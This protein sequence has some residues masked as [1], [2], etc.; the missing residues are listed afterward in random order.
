MLKSYQ[1]VKSFMFGYM[2]VKTS[3]T[4]NLSEKIMCWLYLN[5]KINIM[6]VDINI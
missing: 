1:N 5:L 3:R 2:Y 6:L 4:I